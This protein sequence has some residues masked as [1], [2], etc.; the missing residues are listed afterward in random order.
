MKINK[1]II[2]TIAASLVI[3]AIFG[4]VFFGG[5]SHTET[6]TETHDHS[7]ESE[8]WT[9][10][11]HPQVRQSEPGNCPFCGMEL[12][13]L[14]SEEDS[15]PT[16]LKMSNAAVQLA[17]IQ[18]TIIG[19]ENASSQLA[20]N[21]KIRLDQ[22]NV[23]AQSAHFGGRIEK[24][25]KQFV[26]E[27]VKKGDLIAS[28]YSP[29]VLAAQLELIEAK[30]VESSNPSLLEAT[31]QKLRNWKISEAQISAMEN[32]TEVSENIDIYAH[33]GGT[34]TQLLV[35][36]GDHLMDEKAFMEVAD[37]S[38]LWVVF[39]VYEK[40]LGNIKLGDKVS[41]T[42]NNSS[43]VYEASISFISPN[44]DPTTRVVEVR[45]DINNRSGALKPDM[46]VKG[47]IASP[48]T[49]GLLVPKSAVLWTG[50]R[51][52]VYTKT[53][54]G[55]SFRL[56]EVTLGP[57][58]GDAYLVE[59]GLN[60]GDEVVTNGAFTLDA[61]AQ[62]QGKISMMNQV[63][64]AA[65]PTENTFTEVSLPEAKNFESSVNSTFQDQLLALAMAYLPLKDA[66]VEGNASAIRKAAIP[67]QTKLEKV[68]MTLAK[69]DAHMH[70]MALLGPMQDALARIISAENRD[71][72][73]LQFIN[74]SKALIN[75]VRSF[76]TNYESPLYV[77]FC[78][79][80]NNDQGA[81]WL[82]TEE[83]IVNPYFGDMMLTCGSIEETLTK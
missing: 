59:S 51:S 37:L 80:A 41:F 26:G 21:G 27:E 83:N 10:S 74:L 45:A 40:D 57:R 79:M 54:E 77:Q 6:A 24:L 72:Q 66:M 71:T 78:P 23:H 22:R 32:R 25:Y 44:V 7:R 49:N 39:D 30:K 8:L 75:A 60:A 14:S 76:G 65:S 61:E 58:V 70:W 35:K 17:N 56:N 62:L 2:L 48:T 9:C 4:A 69:G 20:L 16:I 1:S 15:D 18:T 3:G 36:T 81:I 12:I 47:A 68:D 55:F 13:P 82:S 42:P 34:I 67:V 52:V 64:T 31:R 11:M 50:K 5:N 73:R 38:E 63:K 19:N 29:E 53:S 46:F 43:K 28:V 33:H